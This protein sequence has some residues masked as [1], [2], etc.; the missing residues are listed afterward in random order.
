MGVLCLYT[1]S[2]HLNIVFFV[3]FYYYRLCTNNSSALYCKIYLG[4]E[5]TTLTI[6]VDE[7]L[8]AKAFKQAEKLGIPLTLVVKNALKNFV[9]FPQIIIG[10]PEEIHV[11][12]QIQKKMDAI[13]AELNKKRK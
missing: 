4:S 12:T 1:E 10:L 9:D 2:V 6:R 5:M 3:L 8:K 13:T 7:K 11:T